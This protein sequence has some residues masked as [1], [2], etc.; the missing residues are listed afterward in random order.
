[1]HFDGFAAGNRPFTKEL[2]DALAAIVQ[3]SGY[4]LVAPLVLVNLIRDRREAVEVR[5]VREVVGALVAAFAVSGVVALVQGVRFASD[6]PRG[7][8]TSPNIFAAFVAF[9]L[10]FLDEIEIENPRFQF[11]PLGLLF[12]TLGVLWLCVASPFAA[13]AAFVGLFCSWAARPNVKKLRIIRLAVIC[14]VALAFSLSWGRNP[15]LQNARADF[16]RLASDNQKVK[17]Q[18]IEWQ[19]ATRWNVPKERS[20]ATGVGPGNYQLNIGPLYQYD[21]IPNE[22]KMP[23]D[24]NNLYL[25]QAMSI[26]ILGL[27]ALLWVLWH[28]ARLAWRGAQSGSWLG[29]GVFASLGAWIFVNSFTAMIVR[30]AGLLLALFFALAV[31][32]GSNAN[33][34]DKSN[35]NEL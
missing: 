8:W 34:G 13:I 21:T 18:F 7:L 28:F 24:S 5:R 11:V 29:A 31:I 17:K 1:M 6:V 9:L 10:P 25:V 3:W 35:G 22:E 30:G 19:V 26:G 33:A 4:F 20:F 2:K 32:A 23:P 27:G 15:T 16:A 12:F 14:F